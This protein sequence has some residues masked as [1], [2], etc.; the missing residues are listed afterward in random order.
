MLNGICKFYKNYKTDV[1]LTHINRF[2]TDFKG[3][4]WE[5]GVPITSLSFFLHSLHFLIIL[6]VWLTSNTNHSVNIKIT[7]L[8]SAE[9]NALG[10]CL[11]PLQPAALLS[12]ALRAKRV[13]NEPKKL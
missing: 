12:T 11:H 8:P 7:K 1:L 9:P 2:K 4:V 13:N 5:N 10:I 6:D 3:F